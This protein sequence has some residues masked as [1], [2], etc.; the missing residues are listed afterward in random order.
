MLLLRRAIACALLAA[1]CAPALPPRPAGTPEVK[2]QKT[3]P[4]VAAVGSADDLGAARSA[5]EA[6]PLDAPDRPARRA[7]IER[8]LLGQAGHALDDGHLDE[9]WE[10]LKQTFTLYDADELRAQVS[11]L[12]LLSAVE[13]AE[14]ALRRRGLHQ[15][16]IAVLAV[17]IALGS[18]DGPRKRYAELTGWLR[19]GGAGTSS[20]ELTSLDGRERMIEDLEAAAR[21]WPSPFVI[22]QLRALYL[23]RPDPNDL[24][25]STN[26]RMR[27]GAD[28]RELLQGGPRAGIAYEL[29]RLYLRVSRPDEAVAALKKLEGQP[30]DDK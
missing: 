17:E 16:V 26:R 10:Q 18:A 15:E 4:P 6:L 14:K 1:G 7:A 23:E 30:G 27:R 12:P 20:D 13:K 28:L 11:D 22:D 9:A 24:L 8:W 5:N 3:L 21:L 19:S 29:A 2:A 25:G